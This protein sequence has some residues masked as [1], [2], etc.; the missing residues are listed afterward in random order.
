LRKTHEPTNKEPSFSIATGST[1]S[2]PKIFQRRTPIK[3]AYSGFDKHSNNGHLPP[4]AVEAQST[5]DTDTIIVPIEKLPLQKDK[6]SEV[7]RGGEKHIMIGE[8]TRYGK[9]GTPAREK[10]T[11]YHID[12]NQH[13]DRLRDKL[14][15]GSRLR[16][17]RTFS[18]G[19][20]KS[21]SLE[22]EQIT[23]RLHNSKTNKQPCPKYLHEK[24]AFVRRFL[25]KEE[26]EKSLS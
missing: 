7:A 4:S 1:K 16:S 5:Q 6:K 25:T 10:N 24:Y 17:S 23:S 14:K 9:Q 15:S 8:K 18:G 26:I 2:R 3:S 21:L 20:H 22:C 19:G 12:R 13:L 11:I